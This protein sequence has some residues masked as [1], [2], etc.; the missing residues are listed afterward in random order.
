MHL[1]LPCALEV[2]KAVNDGAEILKQQIVHAFL[3]RERDPRTKMINMSL[4]KL[5]RKC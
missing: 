4:I 1:A 5:R 2:T 3:D